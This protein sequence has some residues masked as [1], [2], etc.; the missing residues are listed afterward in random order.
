MS[1]KAY[2][3]KNALHQRIRDKQRQAKPSTRG[4][5]STISS[6]TFIYDPQKNSYSFETFIFYKSTST[7]ILKRQIISNK[8][9]Q[10]NNILQVQPTS[11]SDYQK[12][13]FSSK[14][15]FSS[16]YQNLSNLE[17][18]LPTHICSIM[19]TSQSRFSILGVGVC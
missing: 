2:R 11:A 16:W 15:P 3:G 14:S 9:L 18:A 4:K 19:Q 17:V 10:S 13:I 6:H 5:Q 12:I 8:C 1:T 7:K